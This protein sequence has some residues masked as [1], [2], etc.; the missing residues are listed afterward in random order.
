MEEKKD[1]MK[2]SSQVRVTV[3][4]RN[5]FGRAFA[6]SVL[7]CVALSALLLISAILQ[8][9]LPAIVFGLFLF[10]AITEAG[11]FYNLM[12]KED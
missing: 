10:V 8:L 12:K 7:L 9:V 5:L 11:N 2:Y 6:L 4:D 3:M 1:G